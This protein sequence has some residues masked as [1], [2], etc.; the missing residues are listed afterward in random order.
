MTP[1]DRILSAMI[2][3]MKE[4]NDDL[5]LPERIWH[6]LA[7]AAFRVIEAP[8]GTETDS[9]GPFCNCDNTGYDATHRTDCP[10]YVVGTDGGESV[11]LSHPR[12]CGRMICPPTNDC[13][14][15]P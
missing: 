1:R 3:A 5:R 4:A 11:I 10:L 14:I 9:T 15:C 6:E 2:Q 13:T 8:L 12:S 7:E